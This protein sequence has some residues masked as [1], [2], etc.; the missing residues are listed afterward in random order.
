MPVPR[1]VIVIGVVMT[2]SAD[3]AVGAGPV[4]RGDG[5]GAERRQ[6][7]IV[8]SGGVSRVDRVDQRV[9]AA[10]D[11][12]RGLS[13]RRY[14]GQATAGAAA[15]RMA[16]ILRGT[17]TWTLPFPEWRAAPVGASEWHRLVDPYLSVE[18]LAQRRRRP[19]SLPVDHES[20]R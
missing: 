11:D 14:E 20:Q 12:L 10:P 5:A 13:A 1:P 15:P 8:S 16:E 17:R 19:D 3:G 2:G 18:E 7:Q 9:L 6:D 4:R